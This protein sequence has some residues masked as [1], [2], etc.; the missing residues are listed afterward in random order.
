MVI[1]GTSGIGAATAE[2]LRG[3]NWRVISTGISD[4]EVAAAQPDAH[5]LDVRDAAAVRAF[6]TGIPRIDGL[7]NAAGITGRG[8]PV[9][10]AVF[11]A[12]IDVNLTGTMR[13]AVAAYPALKRSGGAMV[14]IASVLGYAGTPRVPAY[15]ASK[16]GVINLTR[17][18]AALWAEDGVRVNAV[19]PGYIETPMTEPVRETRDQEDAVLERTQLRRWGQPAEVAELI[20]WLLSEKASFVTGSTHL[21][22]GGYLS[23]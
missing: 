19:A 16:A 23:V 15:A 5:R 8:A 2:L 7:V 20:V 21:V 22:D 4:D 13:C 17:A 18:L 3:E 14:N 10:L 6:F 11:E 12:V 1:G 9:D